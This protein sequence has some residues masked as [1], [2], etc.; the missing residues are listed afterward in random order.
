MLFLNDLAPI[1]LHL[2]LLGVLLDAAANSLMPNVLGPVLDAIIV[3]SQ[4]VLLS[5]L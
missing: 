5:I 1:L 4:K 3:L 2:K